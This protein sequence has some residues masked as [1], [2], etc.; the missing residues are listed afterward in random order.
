MFLSAARDA[1]NVVMIISEESKHTLF[2]N[3]HSHLC[4]SN[5]AHEYIFSINSQKRDNKYC[6]KHAKM[7]KEHTSW[8]IMPET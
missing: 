4:F 1:P 7:Q 8:Q 2:Q 3:S 6:R 5:F